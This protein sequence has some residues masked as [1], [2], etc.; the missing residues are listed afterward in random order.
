MPRIMPRRMP[1]AALLRVKCKRTLLAYP[2]RLMLAPWSLY[3]ARCCSISKHLVGAGRWGTAA[4]GPWVLR[5]VTCIM[6]WQGV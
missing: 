3:A 1:R 6:L 5:Y 4:S 2:S